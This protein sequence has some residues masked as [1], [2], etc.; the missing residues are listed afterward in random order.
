MT[1]AKLLVMVTALA[2]LVA[3][4][5]AHAGSYTDAN[6]AYQ[7]GEWQVAITQY[8]E[9]VAANVVHPDLYYNLG[10]AYFRTGKLGPAIYNYE[11]AL[12][13]DPGFADSHHNLALARETV[14]SR[15]EDRLK[16]AEED[17]LWIELA[18]F[19]STGELTVFFMAFNLL[20]FGGLIVRRFL[21][22]GIART[23]ITVTSGFTGLGLA[24]FAVILALHIHFM[25]NKRM[26]IVLADEVKMREGTD[27]S[28]A[29]RSPIHAGLRVEIIGGKP[30][31]GNDLGWLRIE[32]ANKA[33]G[34]V[35]EKTIGEL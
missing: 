21:S 27:L 3:A 5:D 31:I 1:R 20:L 13:L 2:T 19:F 12:R 14:A 32:L 30:G 11:R 9:L 35:P 24:F 33:E 18:T 23:M 22:R 29:E 26:G 15:W 4:S 34:W 8:E 7:A 28:S 16:G 6:R 25:E 10:N 17:P